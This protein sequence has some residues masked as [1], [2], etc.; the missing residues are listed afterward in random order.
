MFF[1]SCPDALH[2]THKI[3]VMHSIPSKL[4]FSSITPQLKVEAATQ[5]ICK[6]L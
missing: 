4:L 6:T 1:A 2:T 5:C 3:P